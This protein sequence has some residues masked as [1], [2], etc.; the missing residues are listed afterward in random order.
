MTFKP[1]INYLIR[2]HVKKDQRTPSLV[3]GSMIQRVVVIASEKHATEAS[4]YVSQ[5]RSRG[6][7][8]VEFFLA[9]SSAKNEAKF[10]NHSKAVTFSPKNFSLFGA[11]RTKPELERALLEK[12]DVLIDLNLG[13]SIEADWFIVQLNAKWKVGKKLK[14]REYL[15]DLMIDGNLD[16]RQ[17]V[18]QIDEYL[19]NLNK[20]KAA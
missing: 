13:Q 14:N 4:E 3:Y 7:Q 19:L 11:P 8:T 12:Y 9:F 2:K 15:L 20:P 6:V 5:L 17:L 1:I 18:N 10:Q 16:C